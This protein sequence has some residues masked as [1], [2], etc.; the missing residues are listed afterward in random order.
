VIAVLRRVTLLLVLGACGFSSRSGGGDAS[1]PPDGGN[2]MPDGSPD[3]D[4]DGDGVSDAIDNCVMAKNADQHDEDADLRGDACDRCPGW[5]SAMDPDTD[6]DLVG[7]DCDPR[8][9]TP[10]DTAVLFEPFVAA[11]SIATWQQTAGTW[12]V[13]DDKLVQ[14]STSGIP[15]IE[16]PLEYDHAY[17][18]TRLHVAT[19]NTGDPTFS[20]GVTAGVANAAG[21]LYDCYVT[22]NHGPEV[23]AYYGQP[24]GLAK[25]ER[26]PWSGMLVAGADVTLSIA[27]TGTPGTASCAVLSTPGAT[28]G[29]SAGGAH[30]GRAGVFTDALAADFDYLFVVEIGQ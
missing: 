11:S 9:S 25:T 13:R 29:P 2:G 24:G 6:G 12:T 4:S 14:A 8:P 18:I 28:L 3:A 10:G 17:V 26:V 5:A 30:R 23:L 16:T 7:D 19:L 21:R 22:T 20:A 15:V 1:N 27:L